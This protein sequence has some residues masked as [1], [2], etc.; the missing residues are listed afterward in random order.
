MYIS[1]CKILNLFSVLEL[2][3]IKRLKYPFLVFPVYFNTAGQT[4]GRVYI[5]QGYISRDYIHA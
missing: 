2:N 3:N 5:D 1:I 4:D